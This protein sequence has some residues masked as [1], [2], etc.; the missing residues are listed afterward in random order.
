MTGALHLPITER[1]L[2]DAVLEAAEVLG[3]LAYHTWLSARSAAGFP[4]LVL[5]HPGQG[6]V[7]FAELKGERG[8]RT[9]AQAA[10]GEALASCPGVEYHC[11]RPEQWR[12]GTIERALAGGHDAGH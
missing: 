6:R 2:Q 8:E 7:L 10:W 11:W 3:Y 1:Q 12:D 5:V 4:D 9:P